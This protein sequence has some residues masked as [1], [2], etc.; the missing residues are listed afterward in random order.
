L[1]VLVQRSAV[2]AGSALPVE[3]GL[4]ADLAQ[5]ECFAAL[6]SLTRSHTHRAVP[7]TDHPH[8]LLQALTRPVA[9]LVVFGDPG[10]LARRSQWHGALDHLDESA[11]RLEQALITTL[12]ELAGAGA[13]R[14]QPAQEPSGV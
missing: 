4:P 13:A 5:R 11:G 8:A 2:V 9:R 3:V 10:T 7:F 6:V 1:R 12:A 14:A